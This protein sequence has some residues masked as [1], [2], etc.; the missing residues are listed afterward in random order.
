MIGGKL[1]D[2]F[3]HRRGQPPYIARVN[4]GDV[5]HVSIGES[6]AW[7]S[8]KA[9]HGVA[10][11]ERYILWRLRQGLELRSIRLQMLIA[12]LFLYYN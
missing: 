11:E 6:R 3:R 9:L 12:H 2:I 10:G 1:V 7:R 4:I 5:A 8:T